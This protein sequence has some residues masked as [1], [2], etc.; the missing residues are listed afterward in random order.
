[1]RP[2]TPGVTAD[3]P[4][5]AARLA[6]LSIGAFA[7]L[8]SHR[9]ATFLQPRLWA[10]EGTRFFQDAYN[11]PGLVSV[12]TPVVGY[13]VVLPRLVAWL[14]VQLPL[15][16]APALFTFVAGA[17]Q[18]LPALFLVS[19][20]MAHAGPRW[21]RLLLGA[22][23]LASP[24]WEVHANLTNA[25]W[26]LAVL[27]GLVL[28]ALPP[29]SHSG[30]LFDAATLLACGF[31]GPFALLMAPVAF[32]RCLF[33]RDGSWSR[34]LLAVV[35]AGACVQ[36]PVLL[37]S[38]RLGVGAH[39]EGWG[40]PGRAPLGAAP[41]KLIYMLSSRVFIPAFTGTEGNV[42]FNLHQANRFVLAVFVCSGGV[43]VVVAAMLSA[44][45]WLRLFAAYCFLVLGASLA[46]PIGSLQLSQWDWLISAPG[47]ERYFLLPVVGFSALVIWA[48]T[49]IPWTI[50]RWAAGGVLL[51]GYLAGA[52]VSW[53]FPV[54][55][56]HELAAYERALADAPSGAT[57]T[58]P[59]N[60]DGWAMHLVKP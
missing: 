44:P 36:L 49:E 46:S 14:G 30:R 34:W 42:Y 26:H 15:R 32:A 40:G 5:S 50:A 3:R 21:L 11:R 45:T 58:V 54:P 19:G 2:S 20:R 8:A 22:I 35:V 7:L 47:G 53:R 57:I 37:E 25:Q 33:D 59:I 16:L 24:N 38:G 27:A 23:Y 48:V 1:M 56:H 51:A 55:P 12:F 6:G 31:T 4:G 18:V 41:A 39:A 10:E 17:I 13:L 52:F 43:A 29:R 9:P 28:V 60:P